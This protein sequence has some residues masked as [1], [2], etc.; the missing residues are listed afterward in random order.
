M[1]VDPR[2]WNRIVEYGT[3]KYDIDLE[4][5]FKEDGVYV[6]QM[7]PSAVMAVFMK[8]PREVF[9]DYEAIG[10]VC[11]Q[12]EQLRKAKSMF[13]VDELVDIVN[14]D[15]AL[16]FVGKYEDY[17]L[18]KSLCTGRELP[19]DFKPY[20]AVLK[21][22]EVDR[23]VKVDLI[24]MDVEYDR[25]VRIDYSGK[26]EI[27]VST[28]IA[29]SPY[30]KKIPVLESEGDGKGRVTFNGDLLMKLV[31]L[32]KDKAWLVFTKDNGPIHIC[33][34]DT[35]VPLQL[36]YILAPRVES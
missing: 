13:V 14:H 1:K 26:G 10:S 5:Q 36:T 7:D 3:F 25:L 18:M 32:V 20:G 16:E 19:L 4:L 30:T 35:I 24:Q 17:K 21:K 33:Y 34:N 8:I 23:V 22:A 11:L 28:E 15:D 31:E 9:R 12:S 27:L 29:S 6:C 2:K